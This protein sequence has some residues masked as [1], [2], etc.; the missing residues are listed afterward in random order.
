MN[1]YI[2]TNTVLIPGPSP[3]AINILVESSNL[4]HRCPSIPLD[5]SVAN[6][7][8]APST[9]TSTHPLLMR[10]S[11]QQAARAARG[12]RQRL[13]MPVPMV[14]NT[15]IILQRYSYIVLLTVLDIV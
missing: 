7:P 14:N 6:L 9:I 8:P 2:S 4:V 12:G 3:L 11:E 13:R 10:Q 15:P 5:P 1:L